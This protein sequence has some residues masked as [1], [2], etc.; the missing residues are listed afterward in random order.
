MGDALFVCVGDG[1]VEELGG[2]LEVF[3]HDWDGLVVER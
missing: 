1:F 2:V 3:Y